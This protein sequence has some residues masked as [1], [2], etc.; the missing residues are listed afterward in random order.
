MPN[1]SAR[2]DGAEVT[3]TP[4]RR[5]VWSAA[6]SRRRG[7]HPASGA[8]RG[9]T[10]RERPRS[11]LGV[12]NIWEGRP[13]W[14]RVPCEQQLDTGEVDPKRRKTN[15]AGRPCR[16]LP[17]RGRQPAT[18]NR[19]NISNRSTSRPRPTAA[20]RRLGDAGGS[21]GRV[22]FSSHASSLESG[23]PEIG[24]TARPSAALGGVRCAVDGLENPREHP[25]DLRARSYRYPQQVS[26]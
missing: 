10:R 11:D 21:P 18:G 7:G 16:S 19:V 2:K 20:T 17:E 1:Q 13:K 15:Q 23:W 25:S 12:A 3:P 26:R 9:V 6:A 4:G 24:S 14:G 22:V 5:G 8:A